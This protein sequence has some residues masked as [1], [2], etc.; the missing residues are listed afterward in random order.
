MKLFYRLTNHVLFIFFV[1]FVFSCQSNNTNSNFPSKIAIDSIEFRAPKE[2]TSDI[3]IRDNPEILKAF[4][5]KLE[6]TITGRN[7]VPG[8]FNTIKTQLINGTMTPQNFV[9]FMRNTYQK[10]I[11]IDAVIIWK[12]SLQKNKNLDSITNTNK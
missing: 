4:E 1:A 11:K 8:F 9:D 6:Q 10:D 5:N 2:T 7:F 3:V 12:N